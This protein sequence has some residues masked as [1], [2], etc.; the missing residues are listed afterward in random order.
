MNIEIAN[1]LVNL[2]KSNNLSQEALAGKLGISRQAVSKWERAEASPDTDNLILLSRL[3]GVSLDE[4]LKTED[5]ISIAGTEP[6]DEG[7]K[8]EEEKLSIQEDKGENSFEEA[9][10]SYIEEDR[11]EE[12]PSKLDEICHR[13]PMF[14]IV[15]LAYFI[16]GWVFGAWYVNWILFLV[17]PIW[18][19]LLTAIKRKSA[20]YF[21]Y[22]VLVTL[23]YLFLGLYC[24]AWHP[25]WMI[26]LTIPVYYSI[27]GRI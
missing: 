12:N 7:Q 26:Y 18:N 6:S 1:R 8:D 23:I 16:T 22:P 20:Y 4:L 27:A 13:I 2:R 21:A 14:W 10:K 5:E 3:Y 17:I 9:Q 11:D 19:S 24:Y 15:I 25:G